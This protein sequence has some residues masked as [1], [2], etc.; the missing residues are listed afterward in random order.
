M[1]SPSP[2]LLAFSIAHRLRFPHCHCHHPR[3]LLPV[4]FLIVLLPPGRRSGTTISP[5]GSANS[6]ISRADGQ[7]HVRS[8]DEYSF[9]TA[10]A[11]FFSLSPLDLAPM[12]LYRVSF[13][14]TL[15]LTTRTRP[16]FLRSGFRCGLAS[17]FSSHRRT[18]FVAIFCL[19]LPTHP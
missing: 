10:L 15:I 5:S 3:S 1:S 6:N 18:A 11:S 4:P 12:F 2:L 17:R 9:L 7:Y 8:I 19:C 16:L 13:S 14:C